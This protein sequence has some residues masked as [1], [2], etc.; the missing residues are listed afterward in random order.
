MFQG[1][2]SSLETLYLEHNNIETV[3]SDTFKAFAKLKHLHLDD[4]NIAPQLSLDTFSNQ[5]NTLTLLSL[6]NTGF[7]TSQMSI[8]S[9][10]NQVD[11][12]ILSHNG[13]AD[14]IPDYV[15]QNN[16]LLQHLDLSYNN[17]TALTQAQLFGLQSNL[18]VIKLGLNRITGAEECTFYKFSSQLTIYQLGFDNNPL[19]CDCN[20]KWLRQKH[21][22]EQIPGEDFLLSLW[23]CATP[24]NKPFIE[25]PVSDFT[26]SGSPTIRNCDE[27]YW[28]FSTT[29]ELTTTTTTPS[30]HPSGLSTPSNAP[31]STG[32]T[33]GSSDSMGRSY[34][35][36]PWLSQSGP[37]HWRGGRGGSCP[38]R[39]SGRRHSGMQEEGTKGKG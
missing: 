30:P 35:S 20:L 29:E 18:K 38:R 36:Q 11:N 13:M 31:S 27:I 16:Y 39:R 6:R 2:G 3:A 37:G 9:S 26:C 12:L 5:R 19:H 15:F 17:L 24:M 22:D 8:I 33:G 34:R 10:L 28:Q 32:Q 25:V 1:I 21:I 23:R 4:Q 14:P 7:T